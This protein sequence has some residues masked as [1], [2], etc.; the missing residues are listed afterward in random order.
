M[1]W[2]AIVCVFVVGGCSTATV[3]ASSFPNPSLT[4]AAPVTTVPS[5]RPQPTE[6]YAIVPGPL[7]PGRYLQATLTPSVSFVLG[8]GWNAYFNDADGAYLG[9]DALG[10]EFGINRP[11]EVVDPASNGGLPSPPDLAGW[12][13][14][15]PGFVSATATSIEID[16]TPA[17]LVEATATQE[18][19]GLFAYESGNFHTVPEGRYRF[20]VV[21]MDGADLVFGFMA[22]AASFDAAVPEVQDVVDS[23]KIEDT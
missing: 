22:P 19:Q 12:L 5:R 3:P 23:I 21:P 16:G 2:I 9:N 11:P 4:T 1:R 6:P 13:T 20:Y 7:A 8:T 18:E 14:A 17:K 10:V 15:F